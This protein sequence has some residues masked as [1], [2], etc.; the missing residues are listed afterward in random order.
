M[1]VS[2]TSLSILNRGTGE[3][4]VHLHGQETVVMLTAFNDSTF[5]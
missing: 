2:S 1:F 3:T 5:R 4:I